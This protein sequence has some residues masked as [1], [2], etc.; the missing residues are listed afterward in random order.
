MPFSQLTSQLSKTW[1]PGIPRDSFHCFLSRFLQVSNFGTLLVFKLPLSNS[2]WSGPGHTAHIWV[3]NHKEPT[4]PGL[5][6]HAR[7][8]V[9]PPLMGGG[10]GPS[11]IT[12][13]PE[14]TP[15]VHVP[16]PILFDQGKSSA[17]FGSRQTSEGATLYTRKAAAKT[18]DTLIYIKLSHSI[19]FKIFYPVSKRKMCLSLYICTSSAIKIDSTFKEKR[20]GIF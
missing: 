9:K 15:T 4:P 5:T 11:S 3:L 8:L 7:H 14:Q 12:T 19:L 16:Q 2:A 1:M 10:K 17:F 18:T 6:L 20:L 13:A